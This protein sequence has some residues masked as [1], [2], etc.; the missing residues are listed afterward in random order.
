MV[1]LGATIAK[2]LLLLRR[3]RA[4]MLELFIIPAVLVIVIT[5][6]QEN[7]QKKMGTSQTQVLFIDKDHRLLG[8]SFEEMLTASGSIEII[9]QLN[10]QKFEEITAIEAVGNGDFQICIIIPEGMTK[11]V[12]KRARQVVS[13]LLA[14][15][16][17]QLEPDL[18][19]PEIIVY[20]DPTVPGTFRSAVRNSLNLIT[21]NLETRE[22]LKMLSELLPK[23]INQN[24]R[25]KMGPFLPDNVMEDIP[26]MR[27]DWSDYR[28]MVVE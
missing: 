6:V 18:N 26:R 28:L 14:Q 11:S 15:N 20:F 12:R 23:K 8:Q 4:G 25:E 13:N 10:G 1:K 2:E 17:T 7:I 16:D 19:L 21:F 24:L 22:K 5:L 27:F 3:D 9:K